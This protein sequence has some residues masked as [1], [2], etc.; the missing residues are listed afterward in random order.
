[1]VLEKHPPEFKANALAPVL[2]RPG[3]TLTSIARDLG[4]LYGH[5]A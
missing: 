1:M 4:H 2:S 5:G 3:R